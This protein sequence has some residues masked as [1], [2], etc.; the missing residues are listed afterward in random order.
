MKL[1]IIDLKKSYGDFSVSLNLSV[2]VGETLSLVGPSG[3]GKTTAL[4]LISGL[5]K[6]ESG[7][8]LSGGEDITLLPCWQ[9]NV[10]VVF[11]DLALF[12]HLDAGQNIA[13]GLFIK[14]VN[15]K[16]RQLIVDEM[17]ELV[18][19]EGFAKRR[20]HT[21]SGGERQR[22]AIARALA[23]RPRALLLDEPFSSLDAPLR[24]SLRRDFLEMKKGALSNVPCIFVTHDQGEAVMLGDR[25]ALMS[26]G[27]I[28]ECAPGRE[29]L[30]NPKKEFTARFFDA[31]QILPADFFDLQNHNTSSQNKLLFLPN[32]AISLEQNDG[33]KKIILTMENAFFEG[34]SLRLH[35][36]GDYNDRTISFDLLAG[37]RTEL[38]TKGSLVDV[39]INMDLVSHVSE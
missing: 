33:W 7:S 39:F 13:Y 28:V 31:G 37:V 36:I 8:L 34:N 30:L 16:E 1:D 25:V 32:D 4:N 27:K 17:L 18:R 3:S 6:S 2:G 35:L 22:I 19:L 11:Q 9:R 38:P 5:A 20:I 14:K 24:N 12:P 29:L 23:S 26:A 10:S 15:K 21:L